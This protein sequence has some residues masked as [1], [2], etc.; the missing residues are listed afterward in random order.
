MPDLDLYIAAVEIF[1][2]QGIDGDVVFLRKLEL[3]LDEGIRLNLENQIAQLPESCSPVEIFK[4]MGICYVSTALNYPHGVATLV[5]LASNP[6][7]RAESSE[8]AGVTDSFGKLI[9]RG[10]GND[11]G[12]RRANK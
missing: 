12:F 3:F 8:D 6:L 2:T 7:A 10:P 4:A 1:R 9:F 5:Q 11:P